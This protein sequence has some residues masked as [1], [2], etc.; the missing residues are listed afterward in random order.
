MKYITLLWLCCLVANP[1][2]KNAFLRPFVH[3]PGSPIKLI[4]LTNPDLMKEF[5]LMIF[6]FN[7]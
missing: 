5:K 7:L 4:H 2:I 1:I 3:V 6:K